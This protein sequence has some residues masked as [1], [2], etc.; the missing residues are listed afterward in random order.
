MASAV[1]VSSA[2]NVRPSRANNAIEDKASFLQVE[3]RL[4]DAIEK[5]ERKA[6]YQFLRLYRRELAKFNTKNHVI[7]I[8]AAMGSVTVDVNG[9]AFRWGQLTQD[10]APS[11]HP[12][13]QLLHD[14]DESLDYDWAWH[15]DGERLN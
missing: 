11:S 12:L 3:R 15:L 7:T 8:T 6:A 2:F 5:A 14:I 13:L 4:A 9:E 1:I 10:R